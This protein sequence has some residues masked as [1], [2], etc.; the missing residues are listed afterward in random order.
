MW[1][2]TV[3]VDGMRCSMC[4][5]HMNDTIR[6]AFPV[7]KVSS[8]HTKGQTVF[9]VENEIDEDALRRAVAETGYEIGPITKEPYEKK[10]LFGLFG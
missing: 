2:Y 8:S 10:G 4:E 3:K 7:K 5:A 6:R 1:R 9:T